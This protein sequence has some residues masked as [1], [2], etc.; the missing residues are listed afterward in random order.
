MKMLAKKILAVLLVLTLFCGFGSLTVSAQSD[1]EQLEA[2]VAEADAVGDT[3]SRPIYDWLNSFTAYLY[4]KGGFFN[5]VLLIFLTIII[6]PF[7]IFIS[8]IT[9][10][11]GD[12]W[13]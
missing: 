1:S 3:G 11:F 2:F 8:W 13:I 7:I 12:P 6:T 10:L 5:N 9:S 4:N